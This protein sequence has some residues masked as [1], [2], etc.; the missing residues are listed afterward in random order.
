MSYFTPKGKKRMLEE[1]QQRNINAWKND[2][3]HQELYALATNPNRTTAD[4]VRFNELRDQ[5]RQRDFKVPVQKAQP[6]LNEV[7][8]KADLVRRFSALLKDN[9]RRSR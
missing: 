4:D 3:L 2:P 1:E 7:E 5:Q 9:K 8:R 6:E